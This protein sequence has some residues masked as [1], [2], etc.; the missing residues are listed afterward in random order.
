VLAT[1]VVRVKH[2]VCIEDLAHFWTDE[3]KDP[4]LTAAS[5][6]A[7]PCRPLFAQGA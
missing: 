7:C 6:L 1:I 3:G 2:V 5:L 4:A